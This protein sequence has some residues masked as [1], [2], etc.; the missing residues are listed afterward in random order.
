MLLII[1]QSLSNA[2][3]A[4]SSGKNITKGVQSWRFKIARKKKLHIASAKYQLQMNMLGFI[5]FLKLFHTSGLLLYPL[6]TS[7]NLWFIS[8]FLFKL[9]FSD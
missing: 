5:N 6:E 9:W 7:E 3:K 1:S 8:G 2:S 4:E